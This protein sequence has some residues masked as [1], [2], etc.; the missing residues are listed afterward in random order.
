[1][2]L[3]MQKCGLNLEEAFLGATYNAA[4]SLGKEDTIGLIKKD[5]NADLVF[6]NL[7]NMSDI[8]YWFDSCYSKIEFVIKKGKLI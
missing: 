7:N 8:P 3:A 5:Y 6:W 1:M 4:K 2:H